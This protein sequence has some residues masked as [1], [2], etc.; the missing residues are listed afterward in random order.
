[1]IVW[2]DIEKLTNS[3]SSGLKKTDGVN[4]ND[5]LNKKFKFCK[6]PKIHFE[7]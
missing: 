2:D 3:Y 4:A 7:N 5:K 6:L 1:M